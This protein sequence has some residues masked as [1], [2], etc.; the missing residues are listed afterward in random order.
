M[1]NKK[2]T[3]PDGKLFAFTVFDDTDLETVE[4]AEKGNINYLTILF[5]DR[6]FSNGFKSWKDWYIWCVNYFK[7]NAFDFI[8]YRKAIQELEEKV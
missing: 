5:H 6:Y 7:N 2:I 8:S 3:W 4:K 1:Q